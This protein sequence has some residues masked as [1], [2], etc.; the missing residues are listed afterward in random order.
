MSDDKNE[1]QLSA[2]LAQQENRAEL[3]KRLG[4]GFEQLIKNMDTA[5]VDLANFVDAQKPEDDTLRLVLQFMSTHFAA[6][7]GLYGAGVSL[8]HEVPPPAV[9]E[10]LQNRVLAGF[11]ASLLKHQETCR[12]PECSAAGPM[13]AFLSGVAAAV[14]RF[15]TEALMQF[16]QRDSKGNP[17]VH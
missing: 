12:K 4:V 15:R 14:S 6:K 11:H 2:L 17:I 5:E 8:G 7:A 16:V 9:F 1:S 10:I 13:E 3:V